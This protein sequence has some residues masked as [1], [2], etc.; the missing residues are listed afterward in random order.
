MLELFDALTG[1]LD[2]L[3]VFDDVGELSELGELLRELE[4]SLRLKIPPNVR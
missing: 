1:V 4:P 3:G 2:P